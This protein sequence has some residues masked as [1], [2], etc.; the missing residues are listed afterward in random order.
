MATI[1]SGVA[2]IHMVAEGEGP[3]LSIRITKKEGIPVYLVPEGTP[4]ASVV[5]VKRVDELGFY[6]LSFT[7]LASS[8]GLTSNK[9]TALIW[10]LDLKGDPKYHKQITMGKSKFERYSHKAIEAIKKALE[11]ASVKE[12]WNKW[13]SRPK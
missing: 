3:S 5:A 1:F 11:K 2:S 10:Y 6:N 4:G 7:N 12:Y 8:L 13:L 9:T